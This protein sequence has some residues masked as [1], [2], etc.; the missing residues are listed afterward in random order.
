MAEVVG[1][2]FKEVGKIYYF[3]PDS[4][5][6]SAGD[7][8][9]VETARG[10]E[11]G[12]IATPNKEV[13]DSE[14]VHPLKKLI[15]KATDADLKKLEN[16]KSLEK[17][18]YDICAK[19]IAEHGLEMKLVNVEYT[20]DASKIL[21]Y[22]T[23]DGRIDFRALVKDLASVFKTRIELRQIGVRDEAKM[24]GGLG[25]CGKQFCCSSFLG[26]FQPV[27]I[28][29]A[30]EQGLSLSPVKISGTCG[31]LMCCLKYEQEAY[32]DLLRNT[33]KYG[34]I[35]KTPQGKG[36]VVEVNLLTGVLKV[37][38]DNTP[39]EAAPQTFKVKEVKLLKDG[40]IKVDKKELE[41]LKNLE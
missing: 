11:C 10:V 24:L 1:V 7:M 16:N 23:A 5:K 3:D 15:R 20:F 4:E 36:T 38:M 27:S 41:E 6:F 22:F 18:A 30:K 28:K 14:I 39:P 13:D 40:S 29:M 37:K 34:A 33:P 12:Q 21:F 32:T 9:I 2:R 25:V 35:V 17:R 31:R 26:D 19:K 8:V